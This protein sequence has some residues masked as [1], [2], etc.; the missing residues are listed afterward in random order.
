MKINKALSKRDVHSPYGPSLDLFLEVNCYTGGHA[1]VAL[2]GEAK[3]ERETVRALEH[4]PSN[5][6]EWLHF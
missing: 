3:I 5:H 2:S 1:R 4:I 6:V